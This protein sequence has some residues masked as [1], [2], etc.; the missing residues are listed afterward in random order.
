MVYGGSADFVDEPEYFGLARSRDLLNWE[1]HPGNPIFSAGAHA[2]ADG[3]AIGFPAI[4]DVGTYA[5]MLYE[6]SRGR[7]SWDFQLSICM[8]WLA[9]R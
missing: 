2:T 9:K 8:A 5:V 3:G 6:G 1:R 4:I 7:S